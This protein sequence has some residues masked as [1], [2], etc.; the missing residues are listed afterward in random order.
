MSTNELYLLCPICKRKIPEIKKINIDSNNNKY[1]FLKC[2]CTSR[3]Q[4]ISLSEFLNELNKINKDLSCSFHD[5]KK[6]IKFCSTCDKFLCNEC[7]TKHNL[8]YANHSIGKFNEKCNEHNGENSLLFYCKDCNTKICKEC[9]KE[10]NFLHKNHNIVFIDELWKEKLNLLKFKTDNDFKMKYKAMISA[11]SDQINTI[12]DIIIELNDFKEKCEEQYAILTTKNKDYL[13]LISILYYNFYNNKGFS[14]IENIMKV[15]QNFDSFYID[16]SKIASHLSSISSKLSINTNYFFKHKPFLFQSNELLYNNQVIP[17]SNKSIYPYTLSYKSTN[18][19]PNYISFLDEMSFIPFTQTVEQIK[20]G[21]FI[22]VMKNKFV[23]HNIFLQKIKSSE[24]NAKITPKFRT[25]L[26]SN[27]NTIA[28]YCNHDFFMLNSS[29]MKITRHIN[30]EQMHY[31][32][33]EAIFVIKAVELSSEAIAMLTSDFTV[34]ILSLQSI[35]NPN[36]VYVL[37]EYSFDMVK[38]SDGN[39]AVTSKDKIKIINPY[40]KVCDGQWKISSGHRVYSVDYKY[41]IQFLYRLKK[42]VIIASD[43]MMTAFWNTEKKNVINTLEEVKTRKVLELGKDKILLF[44][45]SDVTRIYD[46]ETQQVVVVINIEG[47]IV[48]WFKLWDGRIGFAGSKGIKII[49]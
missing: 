32:N 29:T 18:Y 12:N 48:T 13:R 17:L 22:Y 26:L 47:S 39:L 45:G 34:R 4:I 28:I 42:N 6:S 44:N 19:T 30:M 11:L 15:R 24:E 43:G 25:L 9:F 33:M 23:I 37:D 10:E 7:L 38:L 16:I 14:S 20:D 2:S 41:Y 5:S 1:I 3:T 36:V 8:Y 46:C 31:V 27:T 21:E 40:R 35:S 49:N